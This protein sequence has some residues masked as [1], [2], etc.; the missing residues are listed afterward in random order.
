MRSTTVRRLFAGIAAT[1]AAAAATFALV[2][3]P[4]TADAGNSLKS[5]N[6]LSQKAGNSLGNSL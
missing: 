2:V 3:G 1:A 5:G 6:S 4:I